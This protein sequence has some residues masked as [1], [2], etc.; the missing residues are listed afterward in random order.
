MIERRLEVDDLVVV[1]RRSLD[2]LCQHRHR[3]R[4]QDRN[5]KDGPELFHNIVPTNDVAFALLVPSHNWVGAQEV[6][7]EPPRPLF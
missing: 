3:C 4:D 1:A 5:N 7:G 2:L 6:R